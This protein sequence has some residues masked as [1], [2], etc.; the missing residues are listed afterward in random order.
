MYIRSPKAFQSSMLTIKLLGFINI[1][2][3]PNEK[4]NKCHNFITIKT[5]KMH[6]IFCQFI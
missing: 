1:I 3:I 2:G 4:L 6:S 5:S